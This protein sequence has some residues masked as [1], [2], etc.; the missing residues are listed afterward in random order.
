MIKTLI[1]AIGV[2]ASGLMLFTNTS[3]ILEPEKEFIYSDTI[4]VDDTIEVH[5]TTTIYADTLH[6]HDTVTVHDTVVVH[7]TVRIHDTITVRD[8]VEVHD[9][10]R[11][12]ATTTTSNEVFGVW[13]G[14]V[15]GK[16]VRLAIASASYHA[17]DFTAN[18]GTTAHDG[19]ANSFTNNLASLVIDGFRDASWIMSV[20]NNTLTLIESGYTIFP[21]TQAFELKRIL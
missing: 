1:I 18:V 9:T 2:F 19:Y 6:Y 17:F 7:D 4:M 5:D 14:V 11:T 15:K 8:T 13:E 3:C 21:T 20:Q 12:F 10:L 16:T